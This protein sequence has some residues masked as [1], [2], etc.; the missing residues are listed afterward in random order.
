MRVVYAERGDAAECEDKKEIVKG[1]L[2]A[3]IEEAEG[4]DEKERER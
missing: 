2:P 4:H 1:A 3:E